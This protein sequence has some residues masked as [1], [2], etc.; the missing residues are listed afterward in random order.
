[1]S[2]DEALER[3]AALNPGLNAFITVLA[4]EATEQA[5]ML[6]RERSQGKVRGPLH[7]LPVSLK[8]IIDVRGVPT[9]A[10]SRLRTGHIADKDAPVVAR[11]RQAGAVII[12]KCNLHECALGTTNEES[13]FGPARNPFD[14]TRSP[15]GS[16]GGSAAAVAASMGWAS[17]GSDTG[18]SIRIPAAACGVVGLKPSERE[19]PTVGVFPVSPSLDHIGPIARNVADASVLYDVMRGSEPAALPEAP[20]WQLRLAKLGGYFLDRLD[21]QV[22]NRFEEAVN[23]LHASGVSIVDRTIARAEEVPTIYMNIS[24]AEAYAFHAKTLQ[25]TPEAYSPGLR[26]RLE[27]GRQIS[28]SDYV[29]AQRDRAGL[30][31][32]VNG[33][34]RNFDALILP[35]LPI[36]AP[37]LGA[38]TARIGGSDEPLRPIMLRLTQPFNL[39]GHPAISLPCGETLEGLPCG[40]QIVGRAQQTRELLTIAAACEPLITP[41][42]LAH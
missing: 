2:V 21:D 28:A 19:I 10:A 14:L 24:L 39:T 34:L 35:T 30:R 12:G 25:A 11:L 20:I 32:E 23:R 6:D 36:P 15:G 17:I 41:T 27:T 18:G 9:T 3:I 26:S 29:Q 22:R 4:A 38:T 7:G 8:D 13:A 5:A 40:F 33:L 37:I 1:M 31:A 42:V 16:S